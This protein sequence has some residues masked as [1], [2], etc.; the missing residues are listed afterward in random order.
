MENYI[1]FEGRKIKLTEEQVAQLRA[2]VNAKSEVTLE[3]VAT[4]DTFKLGKY[5]FIVLE[6]NGDTTAVILK[7]LLRE[8]E[9]FGESNDYKDSNVDS[10]C[11]VFGEEIAGIVGEGNIVEHI[12]DLTSDDGLK[13]YGTISRFMSLITTDMYRKYVDI[14]D[15]HKLDKWWW[16]STPWSTPRHENSA[17]VKCVSP[18]GVICNGSCNDGYVGVRPF[19]ILKSNIF[20]SK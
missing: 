19:C 2:I 16:L 17:W 11:N 14:F 1:N 12:V 8:D 4:G 18:R 13:C 3:S 9:K 6:Q 5:E 15:E 7:D 20:V 10:I